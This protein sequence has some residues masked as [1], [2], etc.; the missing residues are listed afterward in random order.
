MCSLAAYWQR[1]ER[2]AE[3]TPFLTPVLG[4][5]EVGTGSGQCLLQAIQEER[6]EHMGVAPCL[7]DAQEHSGSAIIKRW[8]MQLLNAL[9]FDK[10]EDTFLKLSLDLGKSHQG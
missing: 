10:R 3:D 2:A 4:G 6:R 7:E 5:T 8:I 9:A 1:E